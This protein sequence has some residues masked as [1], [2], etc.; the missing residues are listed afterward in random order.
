MNNGSMCPQGVKTRTLLENL[1]EGCHDRETRLRV[2][3]RAVQAMQIRMTMWAAIGMIIG[4]IA[5]QAFTHLV[6]G[7]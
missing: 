1:A 4:G 7:W 6:L 3:E 2:V 5:V